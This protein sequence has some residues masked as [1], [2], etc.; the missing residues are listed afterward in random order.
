MLQSQV[1]QKATFCPE[2][3]GIK[4]RLVCLGTVF[5]VAQQDGVDQRGVLVLDILVGKT[6]PLERLGPGVGD[7]HVGL[8]QQ[9]VKHFH[10]RRVFQV[11]GNMLF[12]CVVDIKNGVFILAEAVGYVADTGQTPGVALGPLDLDNLSTQ[13]GQKTCRNRAGHKGGQFHHLDAGK[14][15]VHKITPLGFVSPIIS[16]PMKNVNAQT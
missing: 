14:G 5:T 12:A 11:Q 13:I 6:Q 8:G 15:L 4:G 7:E 9:A 1:A 16:R 2:R 10:T 3:T